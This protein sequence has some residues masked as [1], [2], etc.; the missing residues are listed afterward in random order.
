MPNVYLGILPARLDGLELAK[1]IVPVTAVAGQ[2]NT[3]A[4]NLVRAPQPV[5]YIPLNGNGSWFETQP[6]DATNLYL[7]VGAGGP[8]SFNA[9]CEY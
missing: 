2:A 6:A 1:A 8:T 3:V 7:T 4:H 5:I 9:I